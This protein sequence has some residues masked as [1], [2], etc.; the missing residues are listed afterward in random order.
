MIRVKYTSTQTKM[1][2]EERILNL[3]SAFKIN[4]P[5]SIKGKHILLV[6]DVLTTGATL[7]EC[8]MQLKLVQGLRISM[9]TIAMGEPV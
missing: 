8:G 6:D 2:R 3:S 1:N 9:A 7:L 5:K 4:N